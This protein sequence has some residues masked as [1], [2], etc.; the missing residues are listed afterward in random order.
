[1]DYELN[2]DLKSRVVLLTYRNDLT[3]SLFLAGFSAG[4]NFVRANQVEGAIMDLSGIR[5][6]H[7]S[8][9]FVRMLADL[10]PAL[11]KPR[12]V[13]APQKVAFGMARMFQ[14]LR[15]SNSDHDLTV[16]TTMDEALTRFGLK[17][18]QF[19]PIATAAEVAI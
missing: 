8:S 15:E 14:I 9:K 6:F 17:S 16:V 7:L 11:T 13:V 5:E 19:V 18:P 10:P 1:V 3:E 2:F 4:V 12:V